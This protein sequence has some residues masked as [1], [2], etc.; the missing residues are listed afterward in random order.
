MHGIKR[1]Q[2]GT[3]RLTPSAKR[4]LVNT[5]RARNMAEDA[6]KPHRHRERYVKGNG[7]SY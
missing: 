2:V 5:K 1:S 3:A 7:K 6:A 4:N